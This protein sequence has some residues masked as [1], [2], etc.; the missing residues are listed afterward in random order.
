M[1][2]RRPQDGSSEGK[3]YAN[4][5]APPTMKPLTVKM[6]KRA[7][8]ARQTPDETLVV[9]GVPVHNLTVVGKIVGV[10]SKSSYVLYKVDDS[11]GVCDVKV[12]SDQDGDQTAEP[13]E[14]GAYVRVYGSVKTLAN[15]HMIAAHTQQAVRKITDHNEVTFHMLEVV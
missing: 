10:E 13:I 7:I 12:W 14:V 8:D 5:S 6:L 3:T 1:T 2:R 9:N 11:T 4:M 15:E